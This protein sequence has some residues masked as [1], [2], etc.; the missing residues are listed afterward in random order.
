MERKYDENI[1]IICNQVRELV[2]AG[3]Y[4]Q[5]KIIIQDLLGKYPHEPEPHNLLGLV[6]EEEGEHLLA[7]KHFRASWALD[8]TYLPAR[9]NLENYATFITKGKGAFDESDCPPLVEK[10]AYQVEYDKNGIGRIIKKLN[11]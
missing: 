10:V 2:K 1:T 3:E 9:Y 11:E 4:E 6:L 5:S 8:P 7:M